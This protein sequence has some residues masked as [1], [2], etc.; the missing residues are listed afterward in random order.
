MWRDLNVFNEVGVPSVT[1]GPPRT[2]EEHS[3]TKHRCLHVDDLVD[4]AKLY[5]ETALELCE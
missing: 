4:A 2:E 3:G 1:V 5:A